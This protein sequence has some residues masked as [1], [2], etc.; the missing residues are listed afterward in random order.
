M[1][2]EIFAAAGVVENCR[3]CVRAP[4]SRHGF[5]ASFGRFE[6]KA[7]HFSFQIVSN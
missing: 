4:I 7:R 1:L 5:P 6:T 2:A 3:S